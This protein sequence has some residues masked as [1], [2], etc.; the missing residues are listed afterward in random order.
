MQIAWAAFSVVVQH[1]LYAS[2]PARIGAES[3]MALLPSVVLT[4]FLTF[5]TETVPSRKRKWG[6]LFSW[7]QH[8]FMQALR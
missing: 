7:E 3:S 6:I 4:I 8:N 2:A 1:T 5:Q